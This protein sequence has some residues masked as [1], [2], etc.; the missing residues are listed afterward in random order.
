MCHSK[1][2]TTGI[3]QTGKIGKMGTKNLHLLAI[4]NINKR[5]QNKNALQ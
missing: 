1:R 4:Q 3:H 2:H 5:Y